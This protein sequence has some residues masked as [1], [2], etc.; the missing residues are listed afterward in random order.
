MAGR[1]LFAPDARPTVALTRRGAERLS[2]VHR[3]FR[4]TVVLVAPDVPPSGLA[5]RATIRPEVHGAIVRRQEVEQPLVVAI[6]H[7]EQRQQR[8]IAAA[9]GRQATPDHAAQIV[10]REI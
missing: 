9:R 5:P 10:A 7:P 1:L 3:T 2:D 8:A 4:P 6:L